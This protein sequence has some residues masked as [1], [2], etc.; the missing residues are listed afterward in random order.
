MLRQG[1]DCVCVLQ[2]CS[3][4][5]LAVVQHSLP[6]LMHQRAHK[7]EENHVHGLD[8]I[9]TT[10]GPATWHRG[11]GWN[12]HIRVSGSHC[13]PPNCTNWELLNIFNA[14]CSKTWNL[15]PICWSDTTWS[16]QHKASSASISHLSL[17][18]SSEQVFSCPSYL[19]ELGPLWCY[20][21]E[22]CTEI[23]MRAF[24][25]VNWW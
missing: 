7:R 13:V 20:E 12:R 19:K 24:P 11:R 15:P 2:V 14:R 17:P 8:E 18:G 10:W 22:L 6:H 16:L 3:G 4:H 1:I 21:M 9:H 25:A 23:L 5:G